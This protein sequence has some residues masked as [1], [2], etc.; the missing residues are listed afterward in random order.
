MFYSRQGLK[1]TCCFSACTGYKRVLQH[2]VSTWKDTS[3]L[4]Q[5]C[6]LKQWVHLDRGLCLVPAIHGSCQ[7]QR[8]WTLDYS[9]F[10]SIF[11]LFYFYFY[12]IFKLS[13]FLFSELWLGWPDHVV[14]HQSH[15]M[16]WS[17]VTRH[18]EGWCHI[19]CAI[20]VDLKANTWL[21]R[22]G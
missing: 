3:I 5:H 7:N 22:V 17:Q 21:F 20:Y 19:T 4:L 11:I 14:T 16:T 2:E 6:T 8:Q 10:L 18:I 9:H 1:D 13:S 12:F 15:Q